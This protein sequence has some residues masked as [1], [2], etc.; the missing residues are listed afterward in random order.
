M[1]EYRSAFGRAQRSTT[2]S[3]VITSRV[4]SLFLSNSLVYAARIGLKMRNY[5]YAFFYV[6]PSLSLRVN[7]F[8]QCVFTRNSLRHLFRDSS[9]EYFQ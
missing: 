5:M 9:R 8:R 4:R 7:R 2:T 3:F 6:V 1:S